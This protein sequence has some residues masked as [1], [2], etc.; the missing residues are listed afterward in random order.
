VGIPS[1]DGIEPK[2][3]AA[4]GAEGEGEGA[5]LGRYGTV[6][7]ARH[8]KDDGRALILYTH[9]ESEPADEERGAS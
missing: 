9:D 1:C 2:R 6:A 5:R 3:A 7:L 8:V 4:R